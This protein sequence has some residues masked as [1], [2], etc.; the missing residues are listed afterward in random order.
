MQPVKTRGTGD[1]SRNKKRKEKEEGEE[2][3]L[4][5]RMRGMLPL[6]RIARGASSL[7]LTAFVFVSGSVLQHF[8]RP[9]SS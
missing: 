4:K 3:T 8:F 5:S 7:V 2:D 1:L 6:N 9:G